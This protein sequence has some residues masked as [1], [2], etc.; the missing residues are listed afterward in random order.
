MK[1]SWYALMFILCLNS[2]TGL[3]HA[4][5]I[6]PAPLTPYNIT[7]LE[8]TMNATD[9]VEGWDPSQQSFYDIG[10]GLL[11][12]WNINV[13]L[14]ESALALAMNLGAPAE[15]IAVIRVPWRFVWMGWVIAFLSGRDFMP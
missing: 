12:I 10:G 5:G 13:P 6:R 11:R 14:I 1:V 2:M 8:D 7:E 4:M 15:F 9:I 3:L